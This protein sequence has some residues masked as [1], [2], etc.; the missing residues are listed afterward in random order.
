MISTDLI[1]GLVVGGGVGT[2]V[3]W[4]IIRLNELYYTVN[5]L[6]TPQDLAKEIIKIKIPLSELPPDMVEKLQAFQEASGEHGGQRP[7]SKSL[8]GRDNYIG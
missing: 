1:I 6:P 7:Q 3:T 5:S 2:F 4:S 8:N